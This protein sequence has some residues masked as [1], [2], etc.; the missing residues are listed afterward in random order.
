MNERWNLVKNK[1]SSPPVDMDYNLAQLLKQPIG[2]GREYSLNQS[3]KGLDPL[4]EAAEPLVGL[5][6]LTRTKDGV[7]LALKAGTRLAVACSRCLEPVA[8]PVTLDF[9]EQFL[10]TVDII[11]GAPLATARDDPSLLID[12]H[13]DMH[14]GDL[15]REY[16][17]LALPMHTLCRD[18]C[19]GLCPHCGHNLNSGPCGCGDE[20]TDDRWSALKALLQDK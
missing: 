14:L 2:A 11:T 6:K 18:D 12:G 13:H 9:E 15:I 16:L 7:L 1:A 3:L 10:Q 5:V 8:V 4:I 19:K 17:L 20:A